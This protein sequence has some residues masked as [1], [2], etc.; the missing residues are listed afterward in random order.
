MKSNQ[1]MVLKECV[2]NVARVPDKYYVGQ[3]VKVNMS[4][5]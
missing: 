1:E 4:D 5:W 2:K 3:V